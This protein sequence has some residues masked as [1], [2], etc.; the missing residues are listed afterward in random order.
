M[1]VGNQRNPMRPQD[2]AED[3]AHR[4]MVLLLAAGGEGRQ[5]PDQKIDDNADHESSCLFDFSA[6]NALG[7]PAHRSFARAPGRPS[8]AGTWTLTRA[9]CRTLQ[10]ALQTTF[11]YRFHSCRRTSHNRD[12]LVK[13][14]RHELAAVAEHEPLT[15]QEPAHRIRHQD[16]ARTRLRRDARCED[17]RRPTESWRITELLAWRQATLMLAPPL[18]RAELE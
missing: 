1:R 17:H 8:H 11:A 4:H 18:R 10:T 5:T 9:Q 7:H 6:G 14:L 15:R 12:T 3:H 2:G 16:L 13:P